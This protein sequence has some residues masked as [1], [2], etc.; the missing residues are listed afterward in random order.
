M[1]GGHFTLALHEARFLL[2]GAVVRPAE[3]NLLNFSRLPLVFPLI[4]PR[5]ASMHSAKGGVESRVHRG[6]DLIAAASK[7]R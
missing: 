5:A 2:G 4:H 6:L 1:A 7:A 3:L